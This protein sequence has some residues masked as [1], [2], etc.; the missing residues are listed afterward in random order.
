MLDLVGPRYINRLTRAGT[1]SLRRLLA[2]DTLAGH[3]WHMDIP[4]HTYEVA[5]ALDAARV[6]CEPPL[7]LT[8]EVHEAAIRIAHRYGYQI[9]DSLLLAAALDAGCD[10]LCSYSENMQDGQKIDSL[11]I[12]N[13]FLRN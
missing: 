2:E 13:R 11:T 6:L 12:R 9:Y 5:E 7:P 4:F 3:Q 8:V 10:V 1:A